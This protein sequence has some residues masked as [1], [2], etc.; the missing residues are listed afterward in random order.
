LKG[1]RNAYIIWWATTAHLVMGALLLYDGRLRD[2]SPS[3]ANTVTDNPVASGF[4]LIGASILAMAGFFLRPANRFQSWLYFLPQQ[5]ILLL[6]LISSSLIIITGEFNG[7]PIERDIAAI[8]LTPGMAAAVWHSVAV[9]DYHA[10]GLW[11]AIKIW[12]LL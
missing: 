4:I 7:R 10:T 3:V 9:I 8:I 2:I 1:I 5:F 12:R 6:T 11:Q